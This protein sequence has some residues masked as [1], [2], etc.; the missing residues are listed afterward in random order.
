MSVSAVQQYVKTRLSGLALVSTHYGT[1]RTLTAYIMPPTP[2]EIP[3]PTCF[4]WDGRWTERRKTL[5]RGYGFK[6]VKHSIRIYVISVEDPSSASADVAFPNVIE[7]I[8]HSLRTAPVPVALVDSTT[9][10]TSYLIS[11]GEDFDVDYD[12]VKSLQ[13]QRYVR[14]LALITAY[15]EE[16]VTG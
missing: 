16:Q 15:A 4:I 10:V 1:G 8:L 9:G 11:I 12:S 7:T 2:G 5:G 14:N 6:K 3:A 13:D